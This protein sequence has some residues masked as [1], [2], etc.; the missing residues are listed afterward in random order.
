MQEKIIETFTTYVREHNLTSDN[1]THYMQEKTYVTVFNDLTLENLG[2]PMFTHKKTPT[3]T[4]S[5]LYMPEAVRNKYVSC[6]DIL[7][8]NSLY[9]GA[10]TRL[11]YNYPNYTEFMTSLFVVRKQ[12]KKQLFE[13]GMDEE[14]HVI[15]LLIKS[16]LNLIYGMI[17]N[18][19]SVL[20]STHEAPRE[21]VV[22]NTKK[23]ILTIVCFLINKGISV[24]NIE[25]DEIH[26][27]NISLENYVELQ[28]FYTKE[29]AEYIDTTVCTL[30]KD[31]KGF[32]SAYYISKKKYMIGNELKSIGLSLVK[33]SDIL[34]ENKKYF[35]KNYPDIFPEYTI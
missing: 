9:F 7:T 35:G 18:A 2:L 4:G 28:E 21:F 22:E 31:S 25:T 11:G 16:Y 6:I 8:I 27:S 15:Q 32:T 3:T 26:C 14:I 29:C 10:I 34:M 33:D 19:R 30:S 23:A 20:T 24:Y 1:L 12:L 13:E 5:L 17:D